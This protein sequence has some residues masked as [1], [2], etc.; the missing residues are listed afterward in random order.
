MLILTNNIRI[1]RIDKYNY[2]FE[3]YKEIDVKKEKK[4]EWVRVGGYYAT[5]P[6]CLEAVKKYLIDFSIENNDFTIEELKN[7]ID[8]LNGSYIKCKLEI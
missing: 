1:V 5:L 8:A 6:S 2:S 7:E 4:K 3:H